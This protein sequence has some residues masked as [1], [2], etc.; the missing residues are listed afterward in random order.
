MPFTSITTTE[1]ASGKP[2]AATTQTKIKDNFDNHESRI[3]TIESAGSAFPPII[4]RVN[5]GYCV[6]SALIKTTANFSFNI[7]G[8]RILVDTAGSA[9]TIEVDVQKKTGAGVFESVLTTLPT[10]LFSAGNDALSTN[11]IL[12]PTKVG[13]VAGDI[14]RLD[15][16]SAQTDGLGFLVRI[17]YNRS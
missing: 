2:V 6:K 1:I 5:G 17:D 11:A 9:G 13:V 7:T 3:V 4:F 14:L 16:T 8:I 15:I 12:N 10:V